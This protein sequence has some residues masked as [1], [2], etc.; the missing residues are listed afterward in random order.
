MYLLICNR[1]AGNSTA[2]QKLEVVKRELDRRKISYQALISDSAKATAMYL[3]QY[4]DSCKAVVIIG[5]DGTLHSALQ[6]C[7][8]SQVPIAFLPSGSGNDSARNLGITEDPL[9]FVKKLLL[10]NEVRLDALSVNGIYGLTVA[11]FGLDA[12]IGERAE[13]ANYKTFFNKIGLGKFTYIVAA[14]LDL[15]TFQPYTSKLV[16]D[17]KTYEFP[18]TWL[19]SCGNMKYYGGGLEICPKANPL[20]GKM[21]LT[22][23][24][25]VSRWRILLSLFPA[26]LKGG[27]IEAKEVMYASGQVVQIIANRNL[28]IVVDG[29]IYCESEA[30]IQIVPS[31]ISFLTT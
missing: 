25:G 16:V 10:H 11:G 30:T 8:P 13:T 20:D 7:L 9:L 1:N 18:V 6:I 3:H 29:E 26:L 31:I 24:H 5:G 12:S 21:N 19:I 17:E 23:L 4:V 28:P 15:V 14:V 2:H 27:T 22:V